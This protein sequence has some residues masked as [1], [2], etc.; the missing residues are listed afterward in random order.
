VIPCC[1]LREGGF[2]VDNLLVKMRQ[3]KLSA[4][5]QVCTCILLRLWRLCILATLLVIKVLAKT[6]VCMHKLQAAELA[7]V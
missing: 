1:R 4:G 5:S 3:C 2:L 6:K 7:I